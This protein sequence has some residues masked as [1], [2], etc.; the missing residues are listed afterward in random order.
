MCGNESG[1][2]EA[3]SRGEADGGGEAKRGEVMELK[4][5]GCGI[6][7]DRQRKRGKGRKGGKTERGGQAERKIMSVSDREGGRQT[8][9]RRGREGRGNEVEMQRER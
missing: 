2:Q 3:E 1:G 4:C 9:G 7:G 5:R 8:E 6:E